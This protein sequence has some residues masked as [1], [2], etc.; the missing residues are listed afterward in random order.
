VYNYAIEGRKEVK[1]LIEY[2]E[3]LG[4]FEHSV[5]KLRTKTNLGMLDIKRV[6]SDKGYLPTGKNTIMVKKNT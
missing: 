5:K 6:L 2:R 4:I 3:S 1:A